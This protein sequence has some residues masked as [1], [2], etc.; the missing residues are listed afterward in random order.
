MDRH[1]GTIATKSTL[2]FDL[3]QNV[4]QHRLR[5]YPGGI[6]LS[7]SNQGMVEQRAQNAALDPMSVRRSNPKNPR[8]CPS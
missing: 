1:Q 8:A 2:V 4:F 6:C 7:R 5:P 3:G